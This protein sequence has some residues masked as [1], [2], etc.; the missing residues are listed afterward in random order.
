MTTDQKRLFGWGLLT[1]VAGTV[2]L[3]QTPAGKI[4]LE[5]EFRRRH[6]NFKKQDPQ[7]PQTIVLSDLKPVPAPAV[8][9]VG[10]IRR[11][12]RATKA[13]MKSFWIWIY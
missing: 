7:Q 10:L 9:Q 6:G 4:A 8:K 11:T 1:L 5:T 3:A 2:M 13:G 12:I